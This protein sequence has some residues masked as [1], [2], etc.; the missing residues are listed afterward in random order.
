M[1][2]WPVSMSVRGP[3]KKPSKFASTIA[4]GLGRGS[5]KAVTAEELRAQE[6]T[7]PG[8]VRFTA[9]QQV[10][11]VGDMVRA[12]VTLPDRRA[13]L[14][15]DAYATDYEIKSVLGDVPLVV[16]GPRPRQL[17]PWV[18]TPLMPEPTRPEITNYKNAARDMLGRYIE[19][20]VR[21]EIAQYAA[22]DAQ[23]T[24]NTFQRM[25]AMG[26]PLDDVKVVATGRLRTR[27][28]QR[29]QAASRGISW[30]ID[31]ETAPNQ[32][33]VTPVANQNAWFIFGS[34]EAVREPPPVPKPVKYNATGGNIF[35][36]D[37]V[38]PKQRGG[39]GKRG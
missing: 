4:M 16:E 25:Q 36:R 19:T 7:P 2:D 28:A 18:G 8:V 32:I 22:A 24:L 9:N 15:A 29:L 12:Y 3:E 35:A 6:T 13:Q 31:T 39:R 26:F 27:I 21:D 1:K 34:G 30:L 10:F 37:R 5:E 23:A 17:D 33:T 20:E 14:E 11:N 38:A